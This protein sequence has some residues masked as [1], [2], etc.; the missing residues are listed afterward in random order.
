MPRVHL[1]SVNQ[2]PLFVSFTHTELKKE[3]RCRNLNP[4]ITF[5]YP[6][7]PDQFGEKDRNPHFV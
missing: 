1:N 6:V 3:N 5:T 2:L 4:H 7:I